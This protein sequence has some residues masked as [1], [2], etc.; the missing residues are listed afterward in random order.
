MPEES[1]LSR[2]PK[3][4]LS[5]TSEVEGRSGKI[6]IMKL[7]G[8]EEGIAPNTE[9]V[10]YMKLETFLLL[11]ANQVFIPSHE[12][13]RSL[14]PWEG[15]LVFEL[16]MRFWEDHEKEIC[17]RFSSSEL[18]ALSHREQ[19]RGKSGASIF[20]RGTTVMDYGIVRKNPEN[21]KAEFRIWF[22]GLSKERCVWCWH[23]FKSH[24]HAL[25]RLYGE[26]GVAVHSTVGKVKDALLMTGVRRGKIAPVAYV[27]HEDQNVDKVFSNWE[28]VFFPHLLKSVS[29]EYEKEIRFVLGAHYEVIEMKKGV[30]AK[31][32]AGPMISDVT[33][34]PQLQPEEQI[35]V[36]K[37][38]EKLLDDPR[39]AARAHMEFSKEW[40][41]LYE[42]YK[43]APK[44][45][46]FPTEDQH[47]GVFKDLD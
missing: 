41:Q 8:T 44:E 1:S 29:F 47:P 23:R 22:N 36:R 39:A 42:K 26:R 33:V 18:A 24:S 46:P 32:D 17:D 12:C 16:P 13:L 6:A 35:M 7:D 38:I 27:N 21:A 45:A 11:L 5:N 28:N 43:A 20:A 31:I 37:M 9:I 15:K 19:Y 3:E 14:D 2:E 10:R 34:S 4:S 25:W 30:M 40:S